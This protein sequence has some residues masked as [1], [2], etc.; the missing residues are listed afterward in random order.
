M[1]NFSSGANPLLSPKRQG[2]VSCVICTEIVKETKD[3][4]TVVDEDA[5]EELAESWAELK[6]PLSCTEHHYTETLERNSEPKTKILSFTKFA[7]S[8]FATTTR[9][10][11]KY[12]K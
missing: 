1:A 11:Q 4:Q 3:G 10:N 12:G 5:F 8:A 7:E 6:V 2:N 9:F